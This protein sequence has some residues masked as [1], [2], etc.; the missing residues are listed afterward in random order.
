MLK[1][2]VNRSQNQPL[3]EIRST[4]RQ[5]EERDQE[6]SERS[7]LLLDQTLKLLL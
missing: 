4:I 6:F 7:N 2:T 1:T 3:A 5:L